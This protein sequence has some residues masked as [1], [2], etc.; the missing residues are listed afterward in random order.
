L[1]L[2]VFLAITVGQAPRQ[3]HGA[4]VFTA[5]LPE[6]LG[7]ADVER[8]HRIFEL[9]EDG[10]WKQADKLIGQLDDP[11]LTGHV[12]AQ[13][14]LHPT[15]YRSKYKELKDWMALYA[16]HPDARRIY[17]LALRRKPANWRAP[18]RP[19][20]GYIGGGAVAAKA[21]QPA[22]K[23][24]S[25]AQRRKVSAYKRQIRGNLRQGWTKAVKRL[26]A[27]K[28]VKRLFSDYDM[29]AAKA[30]LGAGYFAAGRDEW[31][32]KWAGEA[33]SRSGR[34]LPEANWTAGLASWR[35]GLREQAANYFEAASLAKDTSGW[36]TSAAAF[37]AA[38]AY[39]VDGKPQR[40][41]ALLG[42]AAAYPRTFYGF[43]ARKMLG[44]PSTFSWQTPDLEKS[45][46]EA[47]AR[48]P[49]GARALG[50]LQV[51]QDR[52]AERDLRGLAGRSTRDVAM[53]ILAL[54]A[55]ANMPAL[56]VRLNDTLF[57]GGGGFDGAAYPLPIWQP[58]G[59]YSVDKALIFAL[60]RQES[61]FNPKA[62]SWAGAR[63]L[64]QLMPRTASFVARD[65]RFHRIDSTRRKLFQPEIN[66]KLGQKYIEMLLKNKK[67]NGD[68][69]LLT[70]A[71]NGGPGNLN[72]WRRKTNHMDDP[73]FFIESIPSRETRIFIERVLTNL[74]I[75][76]DRLGQP[77]PSLDAIAAGDWPVY[78]ALDNQPMMLAGSDG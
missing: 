72:K 30:R 46:I 26:I 71:W 18:K 16:D 34:F 31:A 4:D 57:P 13:R 76:R 55:R 50:L 20:P 68:L 23:K 41:N 64:M 69:F 77:T 38:R 21:E 22:R 24:L 54:S 19:V 58:E 73:L 62:K 49:A 52:R 78:K 27:T 35:L 56:A 12:L 39:L 60:I 53:G 40:V 15:K 44:L 43:L 36:M 61:K 1:A 6:P 47:F 28:E 66:L 42:R 8:Y 29:D 45:A 9:Q 32:I 17:K 14:Y 2:T 63:G 33:A 10:H 67:I 75:Y 25:R 3:A 59:G 37:W 74:W 5:T 7:V 11:I 48:V 65:R 51:G 70:T